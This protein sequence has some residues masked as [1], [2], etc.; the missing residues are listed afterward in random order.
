MGFLCAIC[1]VCLDQFIIGFDL[2]DPFLV[3]LWAECSKCSGYKGLP[4]MIACHVL[5]TRITQA[6]M[7]YLHIGA[8]MV[9]GI[10][11][12]CDLCLF[13]FKKF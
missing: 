3:D 2:K 11:Q 8:G 6:Y 5:V 13:S 12:Q 10:T 9:F 7:Q 4:L 1:R